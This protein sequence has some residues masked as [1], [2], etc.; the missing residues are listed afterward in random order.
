MT[1]SSICIS[2]DGDVGLS[3]LHHLVA[4]DFN[5]VSVFTDS[6]L[7]LDYC[8]QS[9]LSCNKY[10]ESLLSS[11]LNECEV[12]ILINAWSSTIFPDYILNLCALTVNLHPSLLPFYKGSLCHLE[13]S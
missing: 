13:Y 3:C 8:I 11:T 9:K 4:N 5:V 1:A 2:C 10:S 7:I 12:P 6:P